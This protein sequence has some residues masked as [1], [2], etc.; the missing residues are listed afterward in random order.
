M[1]E[2]NIFDNEE[3]FEGYTKLRGNDKCLNDLLEQPAMAELLPDLTGK[4]VLDLGCGCG[5]NCVDFI[6]RGAERVVGIDISEKMLAVARAKSVH[7]NIKYRRLSMTEISALDMKFD[8]V[9]S[10]LAIHYVEDFSRLMRDICALLNEGGIL[11]YSQ[12][13]PIVTAAISS[14][15]AHFNYNDSGERVS[16]TF[17]DYNRAGKRTKSW[18]VDGVVKYHRPMG[19]LLTDIIDSGLSLKKVVEPVPKRWAVDKLPTIV[20]EYIKPNFLIIKAEKN[21]K[22]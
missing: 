3:F 4:T 5:K 16:Y 14:E 20:K 13:H 8:L 9:Y 21:D 1:D 11:L 22:G 15:N 17:S 18:I 19:Q 2:Q 10:S 6:R 7:K 12:E